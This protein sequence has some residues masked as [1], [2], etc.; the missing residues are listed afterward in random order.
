MKLKDL[1]EASALGRLSK[2]YDSNDAIVYLLFLGVSDI[3]DIRRRGLENPM[4]ESDRVIDGTVYPV[5]EKFIPYK[6]HS[7]KESEKEELY[8]K[9]RQDEIPAEAEE[10]VD[11][12]I[13]E[14]GDVVAVYT[15]Y[16]KH[17]KY[18][19]KVLTI[20]LDEGYSA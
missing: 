11:V 18:P 15:D 14:D 19:H 10:T 5:Y 2:E 3:G 12:V 4:D 13:D 20:E 8:D 16:K 17:E 9:I 7:M 1:H 6:L